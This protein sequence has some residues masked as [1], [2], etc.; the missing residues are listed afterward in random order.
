MR[1]S[2]RSGERLIRETRRGLGRPCSRLRAES[3]DRAHLPCNTKHWKALAQKEEKSL[4]TIINHSIFFRFIIF[5][6]LSLSFRYFDTQFFVL[7]RFLGWRNVCNSAWVCM[8]QV[9]VWFHDLLTTS[10]GKSEQLIQILFFS[11]SKGFRLDTFMAQHERRNRQREKIKSFD[12]V[13]RKLCVIKSSKWDF[14][15]SFGVYLIVCHPV[16]TL[17]RLWSFLG[18]LPCSAVRRCSVYRV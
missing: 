5:F 16:L 10:H 3:S 1:T 13:E 8:H 9:L 7:F 12:T 4:E 18:F 2:A 15:D 14:L 11:I 17:I 6:L